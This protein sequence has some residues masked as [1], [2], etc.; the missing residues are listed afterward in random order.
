[1]GMSKSGK[2][3]GAAVLALLTCSAIEKYVPE[4]IGKMTEREIRCE[5]YQGTGGG[6]QYGTPRKLIFDP[7]RFENRKRLKPRFALTGRPGL[8]DSLHIGTNYCF[9]VDGRAIGDTIYV[10]PLQPRN[11]SGQ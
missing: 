11:P 10:S 3:V 2:L 4:K 1:M 5:V 6:D 9:D 8:E 7:N